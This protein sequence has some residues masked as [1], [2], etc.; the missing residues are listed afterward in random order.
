M[1]LYF[2][3]PGGG[4]GGGVLWGVGWGG[5]GGAYSGVSAIHALRKCIKFSSWSICHI[6]CRQQR[7]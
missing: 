5:G 6:P 7:G 3:F 1:T 2:E 4:G